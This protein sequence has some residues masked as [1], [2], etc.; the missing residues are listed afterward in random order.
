[1]GEEP[2]NTNMNEEEELIICELCEA[3]LLPDEVQIIDEEGVSVYR[4]IN[5]GAEL[6]L[7]EEE[8]KMVNEYE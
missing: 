8:I 5:C 4:C 2:V 1:M 3:P 7:T 6:N